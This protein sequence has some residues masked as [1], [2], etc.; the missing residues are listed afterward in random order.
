[1]GYW[2][3]LYDYTNLINTRRLS[4]CTGYDVKGH[5]YITNL[6]SFNLFSISTFFLFLTLFLFL[7]FYQS[8]ILQMVGRAGRHR[9]DSR[10]SAVVMVH[11]V[12]A[13]YYEGILEKSMTIESG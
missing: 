1:M 7:I 5:Y 13:H 9:G 11:D 4:S 12:K 2:V 10:G 3:L 6:K 8:D